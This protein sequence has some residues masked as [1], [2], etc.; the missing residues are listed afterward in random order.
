MTCIIGT[1]K[2]IC[3]DRRV[4]DDGARS[5]MRKVYRNAHMIAGVSGVAACNL[6]VRDALRAGAEKP[7]DL[8]PHVDSASYGLVLDDS[9][10]LW[11]IQ[12]GRVWPVKAPYCIGSGAD[13]ARG[14]LAGARKHDVATARAAQRFVARLRADCGDGADVVSVR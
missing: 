10:K 2:F 5:R 7:E 9:R 11:L 14:Y 4:T 6:A 8:V 13:L 1:P 12:D 3:A